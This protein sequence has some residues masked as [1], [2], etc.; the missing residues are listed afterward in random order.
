[1]SRRVSLLF[2]HT[3]CAILISIFIEIPIDAVQLRAYLISMKLEIAARQLESLG[4]PTRLQLYRMLVR[5]GDDGLPVGQLQ[6]KLDIAASTLSHH[7]R[8]LIVTGLVTQERQAT[9]LICRAHYPAMHAL[10]GYL[11][12]ECC[13][14]SGCASKAKP[15]PKA[16]AKGKVA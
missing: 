9:T 8:N 4:N 15:R 14:D 10:V 7:L 13:L 16:I 3:V 1:M 2:C 6:E 12:D 11:V 5:A